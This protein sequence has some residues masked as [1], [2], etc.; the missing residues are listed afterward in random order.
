MELLNTFTLNTTCVFKGL[1]EVL[2]SSLVLSGSRP[3]YFCFN[4]LMSREMNLVEPGLTL[5]I[6]LTHSITISY[7]TEDEEPEK[8]I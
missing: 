2:A 5:I 8:K 3:W 6:T 7:K 1:P 4:I